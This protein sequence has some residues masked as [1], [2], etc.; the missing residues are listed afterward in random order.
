MNNIDYPVSIACVSDDLQMNMH[1][2]EPIDSQKITLPTEKKEAL[3]AIAQKQYPVNNSDQSSPRKKTLEDVSSLA[4]KVSNP[5]YSFSVIVWTDD[6]NLQRFALLLE[7]HSDNPY[8]DNKLVR[9]HC[10]VISGNSLTNTLQTV[11][12]EITP[13]W[14]YSA[15]EQA[16]V[17]YLGLSENQ[18]VREYT[19]KRVNNKQHQALMKQLTNNIVLPGSPADNNQIPVSHFFHSHSPMNANG[20]YGQIKIMLEEVGALS[21]RDWPITL[22][23]FLDKDRTYCREYTVSSTGTEKSSARQEGSCALM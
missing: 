20:I 14:P 3:L 8:P 7:R 1:H 11:C 4:E 16:W 15:Y 13:V 9:S 23:N 17:D 21:A 5:Y 12:K 2:K 18:T 6:K 22:E 19:P 10:Y